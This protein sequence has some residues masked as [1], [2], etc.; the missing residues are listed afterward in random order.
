MAD[1][2]EIKINTIVNSAN[3]AKSIGDLKK[4][5]KELSFAQTEVDK[6]SPHFKKLTQAINDV[7]GKVGDLNDQFNT[8][9]GSG[10]ERAKGSFDLLQ[11][12]FNNFD[13]GKISTGL[14]GLG[15]AMD[16]IPIFLI[17]EGLKMLWDNFDAIVHI[18]DSN[19]Q[20][21]ER[22]KKANEEL[23]K[24]NDLLIGQLD[25]EIKLLEAQGG[26]VEL[27]NQK[28]KEKL[29]L[30]IKELKADNELQL[31]QARAIAQNDDFTE[32]VI[33]LHVWSLRKIGMDEQADQYEKALQKT[34]INR[35]KEFTDKYKENILTIKT[36][37]TDY[38]VEQIKNDKDQQEKKNEAYRT[39][40]ENKQKSMEDLQKKVDE[41]IALDRQRARMEIDEAVAKNEKL[42]EE[43]KAFQKI[44]NGMQLK[45][46][47]IMKVNRKQE[48]KD[49]I[50]AIN[51]KQQL[52]FADA[53]ALGILQK[54]LTDI[55]IAENKK[56]L[57]DFET[58]TNKKLGIAQQY[59]DSAS[60]LEKALFE[61]L[62]NVG[63]QSTQ[64]KEKRAKA[65]FKIE[66]A[67]AISTALIN[68]GKAVMKDLST[69]GLPFATPFMIFDG[70]ITAAQVAAISSRQFSSGG[71]ST[72]TPTGSPNSSSSG[73]DTPQFTP[74]QFFKLGQGQ[75]TTSQ[76]NTPIVVQV[77]DI[78]KVQKK[79]SVI[80]KNSVLGQ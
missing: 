28:K 77:D 33:R 50:E 58:T 4:A 70:I 45:Q 51:Q 37:E 46:T 54:E 42:L 32:S 29:Q 26:S 67:L 15:A 12:G 80:Q 41:E 6:T 34:K 25:N 75:S 27:I 16:A 31:Q 79:V 39:A 59:T 30:Q 68:G 36:L 55:E 53:L 48:V 74:P 71:G 52:A 60:S 78:N 5:M 47:E 10:I 72:P 23:K 13:T 7:E 35:I 73:S 8:L 62:N 14:R 65:Q 43:E 20:E 19:A 56:K 22:L 64:A 21:T 38:Q 63:S 69:Y 3:S 11:D 57:K 66:K 2:L 24:S 9:T 17:I 49:L 1:G 40:Q 18:L 44:L 76:D 61:F